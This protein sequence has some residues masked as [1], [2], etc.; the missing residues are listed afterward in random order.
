MLTNRKQ[1]ARAIT[2]DREQN[3]QPAAA[4]AE[5]MTATLGGREMKAPKVGC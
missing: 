2:T 5:A 1:V 3:I 4:I